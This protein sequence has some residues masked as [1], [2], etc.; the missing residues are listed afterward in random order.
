MKV[1]DKLRTGKVLLLIFIKRRAE[2]IPL[3]FELSGS[4][5]YCVSYL[6]LIDNSS[7]SV[8]LKYIDTCT[9]SVRYLYI[10]MPNK[11]AVGPT[12]IA[13]ELVETE[14]LQLE[15]GTTGFRI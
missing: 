12:V 14:L 3:K 5:D 11:E 7:M 2:R 4:D 8:T 13:L 6:S 10:L 1:R 15:D 9:G